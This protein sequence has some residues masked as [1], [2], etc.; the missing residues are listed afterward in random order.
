MS[1]QQLPPTKEEISARTVAALYGW[2]GR[3]II[4]PAPAQTN[5]CPVKLT[6]TDE[7]TVHE[8]VEKIITWGHRNANGHYSPDALRYFVREWYDIFGEEYATVVRHIASATPVAADM[9]DAELDTED[10]DDM[11]PPPTV[12]KVKVK[13]KKK[14][15]KT[16]ELSDELG[17]DEIGDIEM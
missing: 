4:T 15:L 13:K 5:G 7:A 3:I 10:D 17:S 6:G 14:K 11:L 12:T 9:P 8:W 16:K 2:D 1:K